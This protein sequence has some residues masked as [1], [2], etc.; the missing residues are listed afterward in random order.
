L[1][2][3][4]IGTR[5]LPDCAVAVD[6]LTFLCLA[7]EIDCVGKEEFGDLRQAADLNLSGAWICLSKRP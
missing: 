4:S 2:V 6:D 7:A 5:T 1:R 3:S